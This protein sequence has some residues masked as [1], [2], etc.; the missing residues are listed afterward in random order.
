MK[1]L[2][3]TLLAIMTASLV[4]LVGCEAVNE[5][6]EVG[7]APKGVQPEAVSAYVPSMPLQAG[8]VAST[9]GAPT[10]NRLDADGTVSVLGTEVPYHVQAFAVSGGGTY[11]LHSQQDF[12]G[13]LLLY[14]GSF[15]PADPVTGFIAGNDDYGNVGES[16]VSADLASGTTYFLVTTGWAN[17][18]YGFFVNKVYGPYGVE[19]PLYA[20]E[21]EAST[22]GAPT[23]HRLDADGTLATWAT[24]V[25]YHVQEFEVAYAG[26]YTAYSVQ[27]GI[28]DGFVLLYGG[29]FDPADPVTGFIAANDDRDGIAVGES[30]VT[31]D[32]VAG[33]P[34]Y[35]VTTGYGNDTYGA[36][37]NTLL[38]PAA[39]TLIEAGDTTPPVITLHLNGSVALDDSVWYTSSVTTAWEL[40]DAESVVTLLDGCEAQTL[41]TDTTGTPLSCSASSAGGVTTFTFDLKLDQAPPTVLVTGVDD[42]ATYELGSVPTPGCETTDVTSGVAVAATLQV[43]GGPTGEIIASCAGA[44]DVAGHSGGSSAT[45]F[46]TAAPADP[47]QATSDLIA[48]VGELVNDG[49]LKS[50]QAKGLIKPLENALR[51]LEVE[52][53]EDA[54][55]QLADFIVEVEAKVP[56]LTEAQASELIASAEAIR[57]VLGCE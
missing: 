13:Y 14:G 17:E 9:A 10:W 57:D 52:R 43:T 31:A 27:A 50:G 38:G 36:F 18:S 45:Y 29:S 47:I 55:N 49:V 51:S 48:V 25:P 24:A 44:L 20:A 35:L 56:P 26:S 11:D 6:P 37:E 34:Y 4:A 1:P 39:V 8:Y 23:W 16:V 30:L 40:S 19:G 33:T 41:M 7:T 12:D 2:R 42:G 28:F 46:V 21:Y 53:P 3:M 54:C 5:A 32:L 15:D 22:E